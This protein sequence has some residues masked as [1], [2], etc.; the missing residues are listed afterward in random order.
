MKPAL[1]DTDIL[2]AFFRGNPVVKTN[3]EKYLHEYATINFSIITYY[4][5]LNGL[6][7]KDAHGQLQKFNEF[8]LLNTIVPLT[9]NATNKAAEI[10]ANLRK[11]G[12]P[13]GH[14]DC[15]IAGIALS[16]GLQLATNNT[17]HFSRIKSL[18]LLDWF[19]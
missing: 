7:Y 9:I 18:E 16:N 1:I 8:C 6:L 17:A 5:I 2:S 12:K 19:N 3:V 13:I 11:T 10:Y 14:T 4:E 15:L